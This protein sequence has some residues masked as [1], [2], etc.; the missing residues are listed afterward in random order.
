M[1]PKK[2]PTKKKSKKQLEAEKKAE[3]EAERSRKERGEEDTEIR[4]VGEQVEGENQND[5]EE[6]EGGE[7]E[8]DQELEVP[9]KERTEESLMDFMVED[10]G[11]FPADVLAGE[12]KILICVIAY[13]DGE[14]FEVLGEDE[15]EQNGDD[16]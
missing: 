3:E 9:N 11:K 10:G 2:P 7:D 4:E 14:E 12:N 13:D 5:D 6:E 16:D 1:T 8:W 15:E